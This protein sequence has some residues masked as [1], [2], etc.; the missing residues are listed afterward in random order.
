MIQNVMCKHRL[1]GDKIMTTVMNRNRSTTLEGS[2]KDNLGVAEGGCSIQFIEN[3]TLT[4]VS[5][6]A[7]KALTCSVHFLNHQERSQKTF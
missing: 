4:L 2:V 6:V 3:S 7:H 1:K 5:V